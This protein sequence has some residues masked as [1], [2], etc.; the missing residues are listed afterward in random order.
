[1]SLL[2]KERFIVNIWVHDRDA[3]R[4]TFEEM[5]ALNLYPIAKTLASTM[6]LIPSQ[7]YSFS[8]I[9]LSL[10][11]YCIETLA[12][13]IFFFCWDTFIGQ[14]SIYKTNCIALRGTKIVTDVHKVLFNKKK[15]HLFMSNNISQFQNLI[16]EI[17]QPSRLGF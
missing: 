13:S 8:K 2:S 12:I 10:T 6:T 3:V 1:M 5:L 16:S 11:R 4:T 17:F 9:V 7:K 15:N 14:R